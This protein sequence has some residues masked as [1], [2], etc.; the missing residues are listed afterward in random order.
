MKRPYVAPAL[1]ELTEAE[2]EQWRQTEAQPVKRRSFHVS[3]HQAELRR[4][5]FAAVALGEHT[6]N[7]GELRWAFVVGY[8]MSSA[9]LTETEREELSNRI[10]ADRR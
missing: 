5:L 6:V 2:I 7:K 8:L 1:R 10:N 9:C 4:E 3:K